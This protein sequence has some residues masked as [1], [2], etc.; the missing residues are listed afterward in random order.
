MPGT[1]AASVAAEHGIR[2]LSASVA[3]DNPAALALMKR[4]GHVEWTA[5]EGGAYEVVVA[6]QP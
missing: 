6:L 2:R 5:Y 1:A 4:L 3:V